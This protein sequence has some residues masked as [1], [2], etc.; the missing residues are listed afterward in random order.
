MTKAQ[1]NDPDFSS[2]IENP[3]W[4]NEVQ[5]FFDEQD[6]NCMMSAWQ[7]KP[8]IDL[9]S[10]SQVSDM[11]SKVYYYVYYKLMP[12]GKPKWNNNKLFS[13]LAGFFYVMLAPFTIFK[14]N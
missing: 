5:Y 11:S 2:I 13:F 3:V 7:G 10:Y 1:L 4:D 14:S 9:Q 8:L 12:M 6:Y